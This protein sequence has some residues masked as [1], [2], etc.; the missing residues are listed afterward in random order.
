[1]TVKDLIV[2]LLDQDQTRE[3]F[4]EWEVE[5]GSNWEEAENVSAGRRN[6]K[7]AVVIS[8]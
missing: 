1:M 4:I 7:A 5:D 2:L 6:G 3:V 8:I